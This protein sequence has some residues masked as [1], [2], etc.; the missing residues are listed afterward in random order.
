MKYRLYNDPTI[1]AL[2]KF[3][4]QLA[5]GQMQADFP[6]LSAA[7]VEVF[8]APASSS[9]VDRN[10]KTGKAFLTQQRCRLHDIGYQRQVSVSYNGFQLRRELKNSRGCGFDK[11]LQS[12]CSDAQSSL[13]SDFFVEE[14]FDFTDM[15]EEL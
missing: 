12:F 13:L 6:S 4:C 15:E 1:E 14:V 2:K 3:R 10:H 9:A 5:W 7:L 8:Y 11:H